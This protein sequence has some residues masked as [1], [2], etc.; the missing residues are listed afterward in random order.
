MFSFIILHYKNIEETIECLTYLQKLDLKD[1]HIIVV[2]NNSS[3]KETFDLF[4]NA[5]MMEG[6]TSFISSWRIRLYSLS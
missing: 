1:A 4:P 6:L 2:D 3:L 5:T